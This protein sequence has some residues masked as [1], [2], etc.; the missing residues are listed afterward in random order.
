MTPRDLYPAIEPYHTEMLPV[1]DLHTLY[2]EQSGNPD[3]VPVVFL[4]GGPGSGTSP[5]H[6]QY[7]DPARYRII[8]F[9]QRGSGKS[10]PLGEVRQNSTALLIEDIETIRRHLGIERWHVF[11]GS[12][13]STLALAYSQAH[14]QPCL[15]MALRGIFLMRPWEINWFIYE[16]R[17][18]YPEAW[19]KF[20]KFIPEAERGDLLTA[21]SKRLFDPNPKIHGPAARSWSGYE[22]CCATLLPSPETVADM[23]SDHVALG[24]ARMEAHYMRHHAFIGEHDLVNHVSKIRHIPAVIVQGRYDM[25]CP[26]VNA[27]DL[28]KAWPEAEYIIVPDAGHSA[29]EPGIRTALLNA[30][31]LF[32]KLD[33]S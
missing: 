7:F 25:V 24:L 27:N 6:R 32:A 9:D 1:D 8:L 33:V 10:M 5:K 26:I 12:W 11:G 4:H 18:I 16:M 3:G 17:T 29:S 2:I 20:S 23:E 19:E 28:H 13:G 31:D 15:T 22:G 30:T 21:Y 14:P